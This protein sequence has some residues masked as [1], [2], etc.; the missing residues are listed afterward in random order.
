MATRSDSSVKATSRK[1]GGGANGENDEGEE[2]EASGK[3]RGQKRL[4]ESEVETVFADA[5]SALGE[6]GEGL[7]V[8]YDDRGRCSIL[9]T[10]GSKTKILAGP[11]ASNT[12]ARLCAG[13]KLFAQISQEQ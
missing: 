10:K 8:S 13:A 4:T 1:R 7:S 11:M 12:F 2:G 9:R 5:M 6:S 3:Q